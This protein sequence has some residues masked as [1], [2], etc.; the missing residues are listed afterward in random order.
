M[1]ILTVEKCIEFVQQLELINK[2]NQQLNEGEVYSTVTKCGANS[3]ANG[4]SEK[5][6]PSFR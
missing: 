2:Y 3:V 4:M 1:L 5:K 6:V